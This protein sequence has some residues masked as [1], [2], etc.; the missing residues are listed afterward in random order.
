MSVVILYVLFIY[1]IKLVV[2]ANKIQDQTKFVV[3]I[4]VSLFKLITRDHDFLHK[5]DIVFVPVLE[6]LRHELQQYF[7]LIILLSSSMYD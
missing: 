7:L 5:V 4:S 1:K 2:I 3:L 6:P